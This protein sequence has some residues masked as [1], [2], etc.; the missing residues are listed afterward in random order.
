MKLLDARDGSSEYSCVWV[1]RQAH[2][3]PIRAMKWNPCV[4]H[5][6]ATGGNARHDT[7]HMTHAPPHV[8]TRH[9]TRTTAHAHTVHGTC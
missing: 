9:D 5:W 3:A 4:P 8:R 7:T 6:I 1:K 2:A